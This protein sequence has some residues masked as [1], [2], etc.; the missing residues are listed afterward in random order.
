MKKTSPFKRYLKLDTNIHVYNGKKID[1]FLYK[2]NPLE[3]SHNNNRSTITPP[4]R[5]ALSKRIV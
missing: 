2:E 5:I 1:I 3:Y 4:L